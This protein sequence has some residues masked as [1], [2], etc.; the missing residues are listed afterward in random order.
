MAVISY[1]IAIV[2]VIGLPAPTSPRLVLALVVCALVS[3]A[4]GLMAGR[5]VRRRALTAEPRSSH[6]VVPLIMGVFAVVGLMLGKLAAGSGP[7]TNGLLL[8]LVGLV[9][10]FIISM[11]VSSRIPGSDEPPTAR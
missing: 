1:V 11:T 5:Q 9:L 6:M 8:G 7:R 10:T 2:E 3:L 4:A